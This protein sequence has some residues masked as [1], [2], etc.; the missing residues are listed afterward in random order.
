MDRKN[1]IRRSTNKIINKK[2]RKTFL[3]NL[4]K[5]I[6]NCAT[7]NATTMLTTLEEMGEIDWLDFYDNPEHKGETLL[8]LAVKYIDET[9]FI[10]QLTKLR[11]QFLLRER[12]G[13]FKGQTALHIAI[14]KDKPE[15]IRD[16]LKVG[17]SK[18]GIRKQMS[19]LLHIPATGSRF[20][21]TVMMGQLPLTVAVLKGNKEAIDYLL[22]YGADLHKQNEEGDTVL[23]SLVKYSATYPEKIEQMQDMMQ[24]LQEKLTNKDKEDKGLI[25]YNSTQRSLHCCSFLWFLKN[26]DNLTPLQLAAKYG[27]T[28][29]VEQILNM[30][31]VYCFLSANDGLFDIKQYDVTEIDT[32]SIIRQSVQSHRESA[33]YKKSVPDHVHGIAKKVVKSNYS[34]SF[35]IPCCAHSETESILEMLFRIHYNSQDAYRIIELPPIRYIVVKKWEKYK[36]IFRIWMAVHYIFMVLLTIYSVENVKISIPV[37][38]GTN[39]STTSED[40]VSRF[41]WISFTVGCLYFFI[42]ICLLGAKF[43]KNKK[44]DYFLHNLEYIIPML[45]LSVAIFADAVWSTI[46]ISNNIP[47]ICALISGWWLNVFFL[48]P[49][50]HFSFLTVMIKRVI[51]GDLFRFGLV[52]FFG[53][54]SFTAG[55]YM[56][57]RGTNVDDYTTYG[58]TM[59]AMFKLGIGID[60]VSVLYSARIPWMAIT[61]FILFTIFTYLL[62]LNALIAMMSQTC[63][64]VFEE[65]FPLW[66]IQQLSVILLIED[67][68]CTCFHNFFSCIGTEKTI[69]GIDPITKQLKYKDRYFLEIHSLQMEYATEEDK[70][71][72]KKKANDTQFFAS[73]SA[74]SK[75]SPQRENKKSHCYN[76]QDLIEEEN[77]PMPKVEIDPVASLR[78]NL[79]KTEDTAIT[80]HEY[81]IRTLGNE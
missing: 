34:S 21:N 65:R 14:T 29:L 57:F 37:A 63:S 39:A 11:P 2:E 4:E 3:G 23:H 55:M 74:E 45:V 36:W 44:A 7:D 69:R 38:N 47:L 70:S 31:D 48:S 22:K 68:L 13:T 72:L 9:S 79:A 28:N 76:S 61:I 18:N 1:Y 16:M 20:V 27:V 26:K 30:N 52:I 51:I 15:V 25:D 73:S 81:E 6:K 8:H 24:H 71:I 50:E 78:V 32:V 64:L 33:S 66:R 42:F 41:R 67:V 35:G 77:S 17:Q 46:G 58:S 75:K 54:I 43:R 49:I 19:T 62:M 53:I 60:D 5:E 59:M 56:M 40:F 12:E 80:P 10:S